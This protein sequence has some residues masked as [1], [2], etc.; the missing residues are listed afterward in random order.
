MTYSKLRKRVVCF[1]VM[2]LIGCTS[3]KAETAGEHASDGA[4]SFTTQG[5]EK[6]GETA[7]EKEIPVATQAPEVSTGIREVLEKEKTEEG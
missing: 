5:Q 2:L 4:E 1:L 6:K 3:C 7:G